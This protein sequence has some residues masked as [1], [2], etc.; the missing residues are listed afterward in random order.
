[1]TIHALDKNFLIQEIPI[2]YQDRPDG[3]VSKLNTYSDGYKVIMTIFRLFRDYRP[4]LFFSLC[5]IFFLIVAIVLLIPILISYVETGLVERFP[6]LFVGST[7]IIIAILLC[8]CG[9]ILDVIVNNHRQLYELLLNKK[10]I[11]FKL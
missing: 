4:L 6:T 2:A 11:N 10:D 7:I 5:A 3:S 9:I 1:M 8:I